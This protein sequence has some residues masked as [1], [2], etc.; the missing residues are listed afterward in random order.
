MS[1]ERK[2]EEGKD[3]EDRML[4]LSSAGSVAAAGTLFHSNLV[5]RSEEEIL[6]SSLRPEIA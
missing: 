6:L 1:D 3:R 2:D 5:S 4:Q